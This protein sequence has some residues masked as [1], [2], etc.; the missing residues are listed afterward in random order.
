MASSASDLLG[1]GRVTLR[2]TVAKPMPVA[3]GNLWYGPNSTKYLGPFSGDASSNL[4][5]EFPGV[6]G[7]DTA[8]LS[9]DPEAFAK[10]REKNREF[11]LHDYPQPRAWGHSCKVGRCT[12]LRLP[13][14]LGPQWGQVR[15]G[16]V[17]QGWVTNLQ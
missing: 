13:R 2:K 5:G 4:I 16:G 6:Y 9:V 10:N 12:G 7:W 15:G 1:G 14:T 8:G 3:S 17:V 11:N